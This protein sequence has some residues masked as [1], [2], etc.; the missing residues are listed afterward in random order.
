MSATTASTKRYNAKKIGFWAL[1]IILAILFISAAGAKLAGI[2]YMVAEFNVVGLGQWLRYFTAAMEISGGVLLLWPSRQAF[3][4]L[5]LM[6]VCIG[7]FFAQLLAIHQNVIHTIVI[8]GIL[9]AIAW[10]HRG[11][12]LAVIG[13]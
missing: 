11:Q 6:C 7:A 5:L 13:K 2:P 3:G 8:G 10:V 4:A 1:K 12:V 9:A